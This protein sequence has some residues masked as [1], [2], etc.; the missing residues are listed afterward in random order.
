[1]HKGIWTTCDICAKKV[2]TQDTV[3]VSDKYSS[4]RGLVVCREDYDKVSPLAANKITPRERPLTN[5]KKL[6]SA[7]RGH[8]E[9][10]PNS[11]RVPSAP[12]K[13]RAAPTTFGD[14]FIELTWEGSDDQ[15]SDRVTGYQITRAYPQQSYQFTIETNTNNEAPYFRDLTGDVSTEY[16]YTVA[17]INAYGIGAPSE[18]VYYPTK[19]HILPNRRRF[20]CESTTHYALRTGDGSFI[21]VIIE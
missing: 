15:G 6:R 18:L 1:M 19:R 5:T 8:Y 16:T 2:R 21:T 11:D 17:A 9:D 10:N 13:V 12:T 20:L 4:S 14:E 3:Y 7:P